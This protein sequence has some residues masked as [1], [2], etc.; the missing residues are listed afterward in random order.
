MNIEMENL[1]EIAYNLALN[2][3]E[4]NEGREADMDNTKDSNAIAILQLGI[5][6]GIKWQIKNGKE[7]HT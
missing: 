3:F 1:D 6:A 2:V 4:N 5:E 7:G